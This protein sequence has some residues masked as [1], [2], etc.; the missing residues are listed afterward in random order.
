MSRKFICPLFL[1]SALIL[2][3]KVFALTCNANVSPTLI[4][5]GITS[6]LN[7]NV[8]N[9]GPEVATNVKIINNDTNIFN[10]VAANT[11]GWSAVVNVAEISFS[12]GSIGVGQSATFSF[13]MNA[14][15][16]GGPEYNYLEISSDGAQFEECGGEGG[17][18]S[19]Y[20]VPQPP[21]ISN[22]V[23]SA[24]STSATVSW[25]TDVEATS[26]VNYGLTSTYGSSLS[27]V[28]ATSHSFTLSSLS[29]STVY[30]YK[31]TSSNNN[32][33][34]EGSGSFTTGAAGT[35]STTTTTASVTA[36]STTVQATPTP[37]P[38]VDRVPP[39]VSVTT[40]FPKPFEKA[41]AVSGKVSDD[42]ELAGVE[43]SIDGGINWLPVDE[44]EG[45]GTKKGTWSFTPQIREDGNY[46]LVVR[47][48]DKTGNLGKTEVMKLVIDRLPPRV[49]GALWSVGPFALVPGVDGVVISLAGVPVRVSMSAVG[50]PTDI[51]MIVGESEYILERSNDSGLWSTVLKFDQPGEY[52]MGVKAIDGANNETNRNYGKFVVLTPGSVKDAHNGEVIEKGTVELYWKD[53]ESEQWTSWDGKSFGQENPILL[54]EQ[55]EYKLMIPP[56][57]Y[58]LEAK[59]PGYK[60]L[61]SRIFKVDKIGPINVDLVLNKLN[62]IR[63]GNWVW[64]WFGL[65]V[66]LIELELKVRYGKMDSLLIGQRA[67]LFILPST[68]GK[69]DLMELRGKTAIIS[70]VNTWSPTGSEQIS[71]LDKLLYS[72]QVDGIVVVLQESLAGV[73]VF[74][75]RGGYKTALTVDSDGDLVEKYQLTTLPVHYILDRNGI[76]VNKL[77]GVLN[78]DELMSA[79]DDVN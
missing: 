69:S 30:Y 78:Q 47:A 46:E 29:A 32:G 61:R 58:Y 5:T 43:F 56:G 42:E 54:S 33:S 9:N 12:G 38:K 21:T 57:T 76:V 65:D 53:P 40:E 25:T 71:V 72:R 31:A 37:T 13:S 11:S 4:L 10:Y 51:K 77:V 64:D 75:R 44:F 20:N 39:V 48:S 23:V 22:L 45:K 52:S 7:Y 34:R 35:T 3:S 66:D 16:E 73:K 63:I 74:M 60:T 15:E 67:P 26:T 2:P 28:A 24:G 19:S 59:A 27:E 18:N 14:L 6:E 41:P 1:L 70:F 55:G 49:G 36:S 50:G 68:L 8:T 62:S 79:V 17:V